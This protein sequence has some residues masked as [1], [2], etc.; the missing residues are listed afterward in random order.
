MSSS[1]LATCGA[2]T[3][4]LGRYIH[5][6]MRWRWMATWLAGLGVV[7]LLFALYPIWT[8]LAGAFDSE[9]L[10]IGIWL[11]LPM[12]WHYR[13]CGML[14][15]LRESLAAFGWSLIAILLSSLALPRI[16]ITLINTFASSLPP[17]A[18][19]PTAILVLAVSLSTV[20]FAALET[21]PR[22]NPPHK[23]YIFSLAFAIFF[24]GLSSLLEKPYS[25]NIEVVDFLLLSGAM[26][27]VARLRAT[28]HAHAGWTRGLV[29]PLLWLV[30]IATGLTTLGYT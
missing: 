3:F 19:A 10:F 1:T 20:F 21:D 17:S 8:S 6:E 24:I 22:L 30:L 9:P 25:V 14:V 28:I 5:G 13:N 18:A 29:E 16:P 26:L 4:I 12:L 23:P 15:P 11:A 27:A 7:V 2:I